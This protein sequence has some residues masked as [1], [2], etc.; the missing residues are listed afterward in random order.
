MP[1]G[2]P[3]GSDTRRELRRARR[4]S[5]E[6]PKRTACPPDRPTLALG[7][8]VPSVRSSSP[9]HKI[10]GR[11][12]SAR[13]PHAR[14]PRVLA[15]A[16]GRDAGSGVWRLIRKPPSGA[17]EHR[18]RDGIGDGSE[19][20]PL[21][22]SPSP[23]T[24]RTDVEDGHSLRPRFRSRVRRRERGSSPERRLCFRR[25]D[26]WRVRRGAPRCVSA[27]R[28]RSVPVPP[29]S[30]V[31]GSENVQRVSRDGAA[32]A[33]RHAKGRG[34]DS[35]ITRIQAIRRGSGSLP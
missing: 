33:R 1:T 28:A 22:I 29:M 20:S 13:T 8:R 10:F 34:D 2:P 24:P 14:V 12:L 32:R 3:F 15:R 21:W 11:G 5:P 7:S 27:T 30:R 4:R 9:L 16:L 31:R 17:R 23:L 19:P 6:G 18:A 35:Q 26:S 25:G